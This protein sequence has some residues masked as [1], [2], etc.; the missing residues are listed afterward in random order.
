[1]SSRP[2]VL[3]FILS[4]AMPACKEKIDTSC[5]ANF[6][7]ADVNG[8]L[9]EAMTV[10]GFKFGT[11][12]QISISAEADYGDTRMITFGLPC[13]IKTGDYDLT[14]TPGVWDYGAYIYP[15]SGGTYYSEAGNMNVT[16]HDTS[17][18]ILKGTFEFVAASGDANI[19]KGSFCVKY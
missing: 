9:W 6:L 15:K 7:E 4:L 5:D 13:D 14:L 18:R 11:G 1:M 12:G 3:L 8:L 19:S 16:V 17:A 10:K 2:L